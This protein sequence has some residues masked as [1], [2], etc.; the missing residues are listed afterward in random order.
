MGFL[1]EYIEFDLP[2]DL[3]ED[4]LSQD[5]YGYHGEQI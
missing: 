2:E 5:K 1:E 3:P 4:W